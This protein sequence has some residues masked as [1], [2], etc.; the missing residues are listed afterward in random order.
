MSTPIRWVTVSDAAPRMGISPEYV[1][2][3]IRSGV[4]P[5]AKCGPAR[6]SPWR[7]TEQTITGYLDGRY[8][9]GHR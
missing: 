5:A 3:L 7:V 2:L 9:A 6:N 1:R 8:R 4:L